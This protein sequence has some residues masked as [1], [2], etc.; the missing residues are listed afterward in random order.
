MFFFLLFSLLFFSLVCEMD[1]ASRTLRWD[2]SRPG[3]NTPELL[4]LLREHC[5]T[6]QQLHVS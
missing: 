1:D 3:S 5:G 6:L 2:H 4:R